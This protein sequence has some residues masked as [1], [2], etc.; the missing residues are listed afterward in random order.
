MGAGAGAPQGEG[1]H[2]EAPVDHAEELAL[3]HVELGHGDAADLGVE[4]V[5]A[6]RVAER[7]AGHGD[8]GDDEAVAGEGG[9]REERVARADLVDVVQGDQEARTLGAGSSTRRG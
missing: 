8:G 5:G 6:E 1:A 7:L 2:R 9:E 3:E 4:A